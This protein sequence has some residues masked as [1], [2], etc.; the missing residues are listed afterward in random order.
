[1]EALN[2]RWLSPD[3]LMMLQTRNDNDPELTPDALAA[4]PRHSTAD[5]TASEIEAAVIEQL[6]PANTYRLRW[7]E[8]K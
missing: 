4:M 1:L 8:T 3:P 6:K 2:G 5:V 7:V